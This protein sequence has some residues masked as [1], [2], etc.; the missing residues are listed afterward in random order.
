MLG[1]KFGMYLSSAVAGGG[2]IWNLTPIYLNTES[3]S[4]WEHEQSFYL[5]NWQIRQE[6]VSDVS[7]QWYEQND[8]LFH[9]NLA[10]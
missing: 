2:Y 7:T 6:R 3:D 10:I 4:S 5:L 8:S 9:L 1:I